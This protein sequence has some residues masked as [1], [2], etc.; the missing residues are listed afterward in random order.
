MFMHSTHPLSASKLVYQLKVKQS[1]VRAFIS[2]ILPKKRSNVRTSYWYCDPSFFV[3]RRTFNETSDNSD[4]NCEACILSGVKRDNHCEIMLLPGFEYCCFPFSFLVG[5]DAVNEFPF[6]MTLYSSD[7]VHV[8]QHLND[9]FLVSTSFR[10][11]HKELLNRE[12]KLLYPV[13][14]RCLLV[15]VHG[16]GCLYFLAVNGNND[17]YLSLKL[18]IEEQDG[19]VMGYGKSDD[20]HDI[21]PRSQKI[22][23]VISRNGKQN[24]S[25]TNLHFRFMSSVITVTRA[26]PHHG[27]VGYPIK[28][29]NEAIDLTLTGDLLTGSIDDNLIRMQ[30]SEDIDIFM[31][32]PQL[33]SSFPD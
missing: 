25:V 22:L 9:D 3:F 13:A 20:T 10:L 23:A 15:C 4:W 7:D 21:A 12:P 6:R 18:I 31:W 16:D 17:H 19:I 32:I 2:I 14:H 26:I 1:A 30:G 27:E 11:L 24:T 8:E 5:R 29:L 28:K 33:G